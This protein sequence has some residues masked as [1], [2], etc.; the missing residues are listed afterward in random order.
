MPGRFVGPYEVVGTLGRGQRSVVLHARAPGGAE[1]A[2]KVLLRAPPGG[3]A[4]LERD[5]R[6]IAGVE[7]FVPVLAAGSSESGPY[8]AMPLVL[9]GTLRR[10]LEAGPLEVDETIALAAR[11]A[12]ALGDAHARGVVHRGLKPDNVLFTEAG[13]PLLAAQQ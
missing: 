1:V 13:E 3:L 4:G 9:G 5:R 10:R 12:R 8:L 11:L 7:G 2:L 6:A